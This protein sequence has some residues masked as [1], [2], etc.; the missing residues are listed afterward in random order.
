MKE[1]RNYAG[2]VM[3]LLE[4][5]STLM[6]TSSSS[7]GKIVFRNTDGIELVSECFLSSDRNKRYPIVLDFDGKLSGLSD[8]LLLISRFIEPFGTVCFDILSQDGKQT[9]TVIVNRYMP[10]GRVRM[11]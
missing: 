1:N 10:G 2:V 3:D 9:M 11:H 7:Q 4:G 5:R 8:M 6:Y